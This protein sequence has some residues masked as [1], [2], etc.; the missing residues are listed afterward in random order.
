MSSINMIDLKE[1]MPIVGLKRAM[2]YR[3]IQSNRFPKPHKFGKASR[4][5]KVDVEAWAA[6]N[7]KVGA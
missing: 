5:V 3:L 4:W 2:I 7:W 6:K 1:V